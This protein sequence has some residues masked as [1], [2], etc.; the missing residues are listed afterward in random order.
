MRRVAH[1]TERGPDCASACGGDV[2]RL[3]TW[4]RGARSLSILIASVVCI[5]YKV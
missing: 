3:M 4:P 5:L 2:V 1:P